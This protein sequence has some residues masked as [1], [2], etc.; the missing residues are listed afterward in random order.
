MQKTKLKAEK[1]TIIDRLDEDYS[2]TVKKKGEQTFV[3]FLTD[4]KSQSGEIKIL[5]DAKDIKIQILGIILGSGKNIIS[6]TTLQDHVAS[7]S[8]S[9]LFI[10]SILFDEAKFNYEGIIKIRRNAS[11]SNAYQKNQNILMSKNAW[12]NSQ[13]SLEILADDVRCTHGATIG[14]IDQNQLYYLSTRGL[15]RDQSKRLILAGFYRE[16]LDRITD[17]KIRQNLIST[18][19]RKLDKIL[20]IS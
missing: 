14:K 9:D 18:V 19:E 20:K 6:L 2:V 17:N 16:V 11:K 1:L 4:D 12:V 3:I 5:M 7:S 15:S 8:V 13:P 10:R